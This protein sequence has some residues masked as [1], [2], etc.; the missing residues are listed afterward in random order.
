MSRNKNI[1][2]LMIIALLLTIS[3]SVG[4]KTD[5]LTGLS[6][7]YNGFS[8]ANSF[9]A[10]GN[11]K[12][13]DVKIKPGEKISLV[14]TGISGFKTI[15]GMAYPGASI[16]VTD[17][18]GKIVLDIADLFSAYDSTG[19]DVKLAG[20]ALTID[21]TAP[22]TGSEKGDKYNWKSRVWDKKSTSELTCELQLEV[23]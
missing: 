7:K 18:K 3:C 11:K 9:L 4:V 19:V 22:L 1:L 14:F 12:T 20:E 2:G 5:L 16:V 6:I 23:E 13:T 10:K 15:E 21:F 8:V 17:S